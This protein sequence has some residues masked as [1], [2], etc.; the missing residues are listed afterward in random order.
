M[1][2]HRVPKRQWMWWLLPAWA[3]LA[4]V[5][6]IIEQASTGERVAGEDLGWLLTQGALIATGVLIITNRPGHRVGRLLFAGGATFGLVWVVGIPV[7]TLIGVSDG[8]ALVTLLMPLATVWVPLMAAAV[9][10]FP[11]GDLPSPRWRPVRWVYWASFSLAIA[12]PLINGGWGGDTSDGAASPW[13]DTFAPI[14]D[15]LSGLFFISLAVALAISVLAV[16]AR[17]I[18]AEG[19]ERLQMKWLALTGSIALAWVVADLLIF[20]SSSGVGLRAVA[21]ATSI[22]LMLG[23]MGLAII[24]YRLY[25]IDRII[26]RTVSYGLVVGVLTGL[27]FATVSLV[28]LLLPAQ[29]SLAVA[30]ST[31]L[32]ATLFNP[33]RKRIQETVDRR[34]NRSGYR[35]GLISEQFASQLQASLT[36]EE[37]ADAWN[38]TAT[39][40]LEPESAGIWLRKPNPKRN[41]EPPGADPG[42]LPGSE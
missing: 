37:I 29:S 41:A 42:R 12:A 32:V 38:E 40:A 24:R 39:A 22:V 31:L 27:F 23:S 19:V 11:T 1:E 16:V 3:V 2:I 8:S 15:V 6:A 18:R 13:H 14:G 10:L 28:T 4:V 21:T 20:G 9:L 35:A 34:F 5:T 33:L 25:D 17:F 30:G 26:S 7:A 36:V